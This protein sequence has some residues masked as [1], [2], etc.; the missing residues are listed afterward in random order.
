MWFHGIGI[1]QCS[2]TVHLLSHLVYYVKLLGPLWTHS[3]FAFEGQMGTYVRSSYAT[4][5]IV[6]QVNTRVLNFNGQ[7]HYASPDK[8]AMVYNIIQRSH[9]E[10]SGVLYRG[11]LH[12]GQISHLLLYPSLWL[13]VPGYYTCH[14][15]LYDLLLMSAVVGSIVE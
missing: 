15:F 2:M 14:Y 1:E 12:T 10:K 11:S 4:H 8:L 7:L 13:L 3:A 9:E 5:G 6:H